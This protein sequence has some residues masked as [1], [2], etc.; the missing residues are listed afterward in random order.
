MAFE[1][2]VTAIYTQAF[3]NSPALTEVSIPK[4]MNTIYGSSF[5]NCSSLIDINLDAENN[6][7]KQIDNVV[8]KDDELVLY[9]GGKTDA[10]FEVPENVTTI[11][12]SV[13][14]S[15]HYISEVIIPA[16]TLEF[17]G[18]S[19]VNCSNLEKV[20]LMERDDSY[21]SVDGVLFNGNSLEYYPSGKRDEQYVIPDNITKLE[22]ASFSDTYYLKNLI[23]PE[24]LVTIDVYTFEKCHKLEELYIPQNVSMIGSIYFSTGFKTAIL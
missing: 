8:Y 21:Y 1:E 15:N 20:T 3:Q 11:T 16:S 24:S 22:S 19:F 5:D 12:S 2:G 13:F 18:Y 6:T 7:F 9:P 14:N 4:S 10:G 17:D 23:L